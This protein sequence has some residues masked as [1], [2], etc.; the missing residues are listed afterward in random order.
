[1]ARFE[2]LNEIAQTLS[3]QRH[4]GIVE[5]A[6]L[7]ALLNLGVV[8]VVIAFY[9]A[10]Y[11]YDFWRPVTAIRAANADDN[12]GTIADSAW[13][14]LVG[15]TTPDPSYPGAHAAI[16]AVASEVLEALLE[17]DRLSFDVT[18]EVMPGTERSFSSLSNDAGEGTLSRIFAG[19]TSGSISQ[20]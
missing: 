11:T 16:S 12:A 3:L 20:R 4:L 18:S 1:M 10:K 17:T 19:Y 7:F 5:N 9:D 8:D 6:R 13:L 2:L 15:N 14:P